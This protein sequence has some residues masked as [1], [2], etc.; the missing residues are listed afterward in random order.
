MKHMLKNPY[1]SQKMIF[2]LKNNKI[3]NYVF[4]KMEFKQMLLNAWKIQKFN[5]I[6]IIKTKEIIF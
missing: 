4:S 6:N 5:F 1:N 3:Y 2:L